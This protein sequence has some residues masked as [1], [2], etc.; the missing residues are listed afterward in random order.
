MKKIRAL[1]STPRSS[2]QKA[3]VKTHQ[4]AIIGQATIQPSRIS[5]WIDLDREALSAKAHSEQTRMG[6][7]RCGS[8]NGLRYCE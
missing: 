8:I 1:L 4:I 2:A 3:H 6:K 7:G 5:W